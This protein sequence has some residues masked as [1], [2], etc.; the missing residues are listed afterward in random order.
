MEVLDLENEEL[1]GVF[2]E[3]AQ[4]LVDILEE[5][6]MSL[7]DD[8]NNSDTIDEIFRAA[9]TL[10]GSSASLDMMELSDFT[11]IVEDVFDAIRDDKININ[12]DLVD[13]LLNSL[14]VIKEMLALRLDGKVYLNDIS[15]LKSK[16]K[17][18]LVIDTQ[19][20]MNEIDENSN[21]GNFCLSKSD[22]EEIRES[23]GIGQKVL[24]IS[25]I[26]NVNSGSEVEN[27]GLKIFN[28]L[29]N[30]G[31][32]LHTI[33]KYEQII[34]DKFLTRVDYYL[35]SSDIE[36]VKKSLDPSSII[37]SYLVDEFNVEEEL[38]NLIGKC[39]KDIDLNFNS[40]L[41]NSFDFTD[42]EISDLLLEIENRKLFKVKL[43]F[44]KN[45]PM[46]T[47]S[48]FQMLKA[49]KSL[50]NIFKSLPDSSELLAD[51]FFDFVIYYL[52]SDVSADT[53][54]KKINLPD[55]VSHFEIENVNLE[56][57]K[58][59]NL[60][61]ND[62]VSLRANKSIKKNNP[63]NVNLI[64]IDSKK[65]D[66]ILNLVSEAVISKSSYNQINSEMI[67]LFYN[68][69][70]FYDYQESFQR[71]FLIDLKLVFKDAGLTLE[72]EIESH[73][74]SLMSFKMEKSLNDIS[75]LRNSFFRLLQNFKMTS[76]RLSRII[77]DLHESVLKTRMLPISN[78]FSRFTRVVR[79]LSKKLNKIVNLEMEGEETELD[80][81]V[82]D[83]LV[84]PLM[85]C[86]RNSMDHGLET[87]EERIK[88]GKSKAGTII[89][90]AKNEGNVISIEIEDDGV[91]IDP[92][93]IKRKLIE[94]GTIKEDAIYSDFE[95]I[96]LIFAP[97]FSTAGRVT[98][99]SGRGVGL[100]VVKKSI[101]K[102]NG[103][104]LVESE[105]GLG[106][107]FKIKLPLTLVI[108]Q[109]LLVKS[110]PET[111]V[112]PLNNVLETHRITEHDIKLLENYHEVYNLRDEIISVLRL[113]K[114]F[115]ITRDDSLIEKFLIVVN[116][117][118]IKT[119]IVVDSILGEEDFV[120][121]PIKDKFSSSAGVVGATTL[122]NGKVVLIIDV[123][124]LFDLK[125][126]IKE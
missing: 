83:D 35:I 50:G 71:N 25:V 23:L 40:I 117:N 36:G 101:E 73:I 52:I 45:N 119:A 105:I 93:I 30:L 64:R 107:I 106:T 82:I 58:S 88:K 68:F 102:L 123:F 74:N 5:N 95:L 10:K 49:L 108:I 51:K 121:K 3:E 61:E 67:T 34:K 41:N 104:I 39:V 113:D 21:K 24:K 80:K 116:T 109:G 37:A 92:K 53:I 114:L 54:A 20:F 124:K 48:G 27:G 32:V 69:N 47:I 26:F 38:K 11:H 13:L 118:N 111:Y 28:V 90:R 44:V 126:D 43:Y 122:G 12:N 8:P 14:D 57:L 22:L 81:S 125:K 56:S 70:Y 46:A 63:I 85:H 59:L 103:T 17:Q 115:N 77:T 75:E 62:E 18:F 87:V 97:G 89:L 99:L 15:D 96:N 66:Y 31:S 4:N 1:L 86:V 120:V 110:G 112:I 2:F 42:N 84:D 16:L 29:K 65:I 79:D 76:G 91:G 7:E 19:V 60:K 78:I 72:D 94:K 98:D 100:D 33:P 6:I 9:H 55:V